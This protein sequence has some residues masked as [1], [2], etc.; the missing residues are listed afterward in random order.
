MT[1]NVH[2]DIQ[3]SDVPKLCRACEARHNGVCG[4][5]SPDQLT[6]LSRHTRRD[7]KSRNDTIINLDEAVERYANIVRGVVKLS[8]VMPDGRQQLVG[9]QFAPDFLGRPFGVRAL[10]GAEAA[11]DVTLCSFPKSILE[12]LIAD[13]PDLEHKLHEQALRQLDDARLWMSALGSKT[14]NQ[15]IAYFLHWIAVHDDPDAED[16]TDVPLTL[17]LKR[18]EVA[19]FL[20]LTIETVSRQFT[21]LR[22]DGLIDIVDR[23]TII[24]KSMAT[25]AS[26]A[27]I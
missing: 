1:V 26:R 20:G 11:S 23:N 3:T 13:N 25:L 5:L 27:D 24:I 7:T 21:K 16:E 14:A 17:P 2:K 22:K 4:A 8:H 6:H 15:K 10:V 9:L 18:A 19:D 12:A